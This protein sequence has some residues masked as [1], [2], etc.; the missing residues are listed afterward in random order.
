MKIEIGE[1]EAGQRLDKFSRKWLKDVPLSAIYKG[2]RKGEIKV[3]N[4]KVQE[5]YFLAVGDIV[6]TGDIESTVK[7]EKFQRVEN[8]HLKIT[9]EDENMVIVEKWPGILVHSDKK[10]GSPTLTD[11]VLSYLHDKGD[12][13]PEKETTFT[14]APCNRLDRNTSGVVIF[15][16]S[17]EGLKLLNEMIRE[18]RIKKYY[19]T[20][21]KGRIKDGVY[22]AY[23]SKDE[24]EN[25]SKVFD[26]PRPNTKKIVMEVMAAW[27]WHFVD[28]VWIFVF[29]TIH[30]SPYFL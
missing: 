22:E 12:Y 24:D 23:I 2:I 19:G 9:Y 18:R 26:T 21:V 13:V 17:Y 10:G 6:E 7:K 20:L 28:V 29:G 30:L 14:P 4:K 25:I 3:N 15:G 11:V 27:Y 1:N 8:K 16:K 5:K